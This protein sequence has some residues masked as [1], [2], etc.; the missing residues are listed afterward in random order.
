VLSAFLSSCH[1]LGIRTGTLLALRAVAGVNH[2]DLDHDIIFSFLAYTV[3]LGFNRLHNSLATLAVTVVVKV[4]LGQLAVFVVR[5]VGS[6]GSAPAAGAHADSN[7][8]LLRDTE[9]SISL[10]KAELH[11]L[12]LLMISALVCL[13]ARLRVADFCLCRGGVGAI[14][15]SEESVTLAGATI[16]GGRAFSPFLPFCGI[17]AA[18]RSCAHKAFSH[19][20]VALLAGIVFKVV[21]RQD[22]SSIVA[23]TLFFLHTITSRVSLVSVLAQAGVVAAH[24][25]IHILKAGA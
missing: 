23:V 3:E 9:T 11:S 6:A 18:W 17:A 4:K 12:I 1:C 24:L 14:A 5:E 10:V 25:L 21:D 15:V 22:N 16:T 2:H 20:T 19:V 7:I 8:K 13:I